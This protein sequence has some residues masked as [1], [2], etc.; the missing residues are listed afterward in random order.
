M[1]TRPH[2]LALPRCVVC[3]RAC[4]PMADYDAP[5][6]VRCDADVEAILTRAALPAAAAAL[7]TPPTPLNPPTP[8]PVALARLMTARQHT[9]EELTA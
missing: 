2:G 9:A 7:L 1:P 3:R 4:I 8:L 6:C 5:V